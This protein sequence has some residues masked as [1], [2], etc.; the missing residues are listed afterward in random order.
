VEFLQRKELTMATIIATT[1][2]I[3]P[4][5]QR[6]LHD[7][8]MRGCCHEP[9][10]SMFGTFSASPPIWGATGYSNI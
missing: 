2:P 8:M 3:T 4:L 1:A 6:M 5:R 10:T 9:K 7:M